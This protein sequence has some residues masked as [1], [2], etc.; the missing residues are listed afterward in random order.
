MFA[1]HPLPTPTSC[2]PTIFS[3]SYDGPDEPMLLQV[4]NVGVAQNP[5]PSTTTSA[6][7]TTRDLL[8]SSVPSPSLIM[9]LAT[10]YEPLLES[11]VWSS[12][13]VSQGWYV[14]LATIPYDNIF[15]SSPPFFVFTGTNTSCLDLVELS[16]TTHTPTP[17]YVPSPSA[18]PP[19]NASEPIPS[20]VSEL[21]QSRSKVPTIV[22]VTV[23]MAVLVIGLLVLLALRRRRSRARNGN[24]KHNRWNGFNFSDSRGGVGAN[25]TITGYQSSRSR[26]NSQPGSAATTIHTDFE[27]DIL[28]AEKIGPPQV[29]LNLSEDQRLA[30]SSLPVLSRTRADQTYSASSSTSN[31]NDFGLPVNKSPSGRHSTRPS[32]SISS[33][34]YP[35][36]SR[37]STQNMVASDLT[38]SHS[39]SPTG[40]PTFF[41]QNSTY[42]S[43]N[44]PLSFQFPS[45]PASKET[46]QMHRQSSGRKRKP[47]PVYDASEEES[48]ISPFAVNEQP[49]AF[50]EL[51]HKSSFGPGGKRL[52]YLIPDMP[53]IN[54]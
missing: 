42:P 21:S 43:P 45:T 11:F 35:P 46:K 6:I 38:G 8:A 15:Q 33:T 40:T 34:V 49:T 54:V 27:D 10:N 13:N 5:P 9:S 29:N 50:P 18:S 36:S 39:L 4:S 37:E 3:W 20:P 32:I 24:S 51:S 23:G 16:S 44:S 48:P 19:F 2:G 41:D 12:V 14:L 7:A 22:G 53:M 26:L 52:H 30:L 17:T 25:A 47:V 28:G 1:F 31:V